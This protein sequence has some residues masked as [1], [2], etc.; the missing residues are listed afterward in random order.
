[1]R[2]LVCSKSDLVANLILNKLLPRLRDHEITL[3]LANRQRPGVGDVAELEL[4]RALEERLANQLLFPLLDAQ[5]PS[6]PETPLS[7]AG[8]PAP[9]RGASDDGRLF[10]FAE[11]A[12]RTGTRLVSAQSMTSAGRSSLYRDAQPEAIVAIKYGYLFSADDLRLPRLGALNLHSGLLPARPG[13]HATLWA[14]LEGDREGGCCLHW[15]DAQIDNG[16]L[17]AQRTVPLDYDRSFFANMLAV[18]LAG[19]ELIAEALETLAT[20]RSLPATPQTGPR[21]TYRSLPGPDDMARLKERGLRMIDAADVIELLMRYRVSL[22]ADT[23][24]PHR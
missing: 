14:M 19:A 10:G 11:L 12:Q 24:E 20:G 4:L 1:M 2:L 3:L 22:P 5:A 18:Y 7:T 8:R 13:L 16:P 23:P 21:G 6:P 9:D 15:M 17:V